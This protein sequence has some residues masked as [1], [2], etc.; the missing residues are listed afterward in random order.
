[1]WGR[2]PG[3]DRGLM[4]NQTGWVRLETRGAWKFVPVAVGEP[5]NSGEGGKPGLWGHLCQSRRQ[6]DVLRFEWSGDQ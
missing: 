3:V 4:G 5:G 2:L 1:M 6:A